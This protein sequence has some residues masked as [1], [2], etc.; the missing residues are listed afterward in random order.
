MLHFHHLVRLFGGQSPAKKR[1][2]RPRGKPASAR[3]KSGLSFE[4]L[5]RRD[6]MTTYVPVDFNIPP[7]VQ[8]RGVDVAIF[9]TL[10]EDYVV[11]ANPAAG[12]GITIPNGTPVYFDPTASVYNDQAPYNVIGSGNYVA[13]TTSSDLV[14]SLTVNSGVATASVPEVEVSAGQIVIGVGG[15]PD[16]SFNGTAFSTPTAA[17]D[18]YD[19]FGLFEYSVSNV[20][21][22]YEWNIDL[23][24]V[25]QIGFPFTIT[26]DPA[27]NS[28]ANYGVGINQYRGDLFNMYGSYI[29]SQGAAA[30]P[31]LDG[32][33]Q[34]EGYRILAPAN[35]LNLDLAP[36]T[37]NAVSY[38]AGGKLTVGTTYYYW[39]TATN[40]YGET[41]PATTS[42]VPY[43]KSGRTPTN[44]RT[45][46]LSWTQ[47]E[48]ATGYN[49]YRSTTNDPT[50]ATLVGSTNSGTALT[51]SD[52]GKT[53]TAGTPPANA[54]S[55][56]PL[57]SY[58]NNELDIFF[59]YYEQGA[60]SAHN[61][62]SGHQFSITANIN[63]QNSTFTG[64]TDT[65]YKINGVG[66]G[67]TVLNLTSTDYPGLMFQIF[68]PMF[69]EN[70]NIPGAPPA[71]TW[72]PNTNLS[73][74][75]MILACDG[76]FAANVAQN[77]AQPG[78]TD[79]TAL[80]T[81][82]NMVVSAFNRGLAAQ[83]N[84]SNEMVIAPSDWANQPLVTS[85][86][87]ANT[88]GATLADGTYYYLVTANTGTGETT[89][90]LEFAATV[91]G[92]NNSVQIS[93]QPVDVH[94]PNTN[95][96]YYV[97]YNIYRSTTEGAGYELLETIPNVS[98]PT[99][100]IG[101]V[102]DGSAIP[103]VQSPPMYYA[104]GSTSNWYA[105]Y[106]HTNNTTNPISGV[107]VNGLGYGF[108]YDDQGSQ[109]S[110]FTAY[111][112]TEI[113]ITLLPWTTRPS[114]PT[115]PNPNPLPAPPT[116]PAS[117]AILDQPNNVQAGVSQNVLVQ[118]F[119]SVNYPYLG[120]TNITVTLVNGKT[121]QPITVLQII[122]TDPLNGK[123]TLNFQYATAGTYKLKFTLA[124]GSAS[125]S[126][127]F[128]VLG[129]KMKGKK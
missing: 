12:Q 113:D 3:W 33:T 123:A 18:P 125:F 21:G 4:T 89:P 70:T 104:P 20:A 66:P 67:Y 118:G 39:I 61:P 26:A 86:T 79:S 87:A 75:A 90:S 116:S 72:M 42:G 10:S 93:W 54:Y 60:P 95:D 1:K 127:P 128:Q 23:S 51:Y 96:L 99:P 49:I 32:L 92:P 58:F 48:D 129:S 88:G 65:D 94:V 41:G 55:Y 43:T 38:N 82:Q 6:V 108:A 45:I 35:T 19:Y 7:D 81:L 115:Q 121:N 119:T 63:N 110:D 68:K 56:Q 97:S 114:V 24:L 64:Y 40:Q 111:S 76:V 25:D 73:P 124:D 46:N 102:D 101:Y 77:I 117:L 28:P 106:L 50:T 62:Y 5:E 91:S 80:G 98:S 120:G 9:A 52:K 44:Y 11:N 8:M 109:S 83:L 122:S 105:A 78:F 16:V 2:S 57:N 74:G 37:P 17:N 112:P 100:T 59:G 126:N 71:P 34:G 36:T 53:S 22:D 15:D 30:A 69:Q 14:F 107:S 31:F 29:Q 103:T 27:P 84:G 47:V 13:A 85:A